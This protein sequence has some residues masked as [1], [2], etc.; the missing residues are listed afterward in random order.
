LEDGS[1]LDPS[2]HIRFTQQGVML[3]QL[4]DFYHRAM[5]DRIDDG[6]TEEGGL[7]LARFREIVGPFAARLRESKVGAR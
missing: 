3:Q 1:R 2:H 6:G 4:G 5:D 7:E